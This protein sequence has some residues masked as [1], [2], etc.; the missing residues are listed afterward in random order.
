MKNLLP[1]YVAGLGLLCMVQGGI[2]LL[3]TFRSA[4]GVGPTAESTPDLS[5]ADDAKVRAYVRHRRVDCFFW[6]CVGAAT[7]WFIGFRNSW[8]LSSIGLL[9]AVSSA[10]GFLSTLR[11][12]GRAAVAAEA[13]AEAAASNAG[14]CRRPGGR[15]I[16]NVMLLCLGIAMLYF[17]SIH[18]G[19]SPAA[20][21][22]PRD[23]GNRRLAEIVTRRVERAF[24]QTG[25][26]GLVVGAI[27]DGEEMLQGFGTRQLG[28]L[29]PPDADTVF[30]IGSISKVFTGILLAQRIESGELKLDDRVADLLPEG[31]SLPEP[32]RAVTLQHC[33]THT[34][35]FPRLPENL[36]SVSN[37]VRQL[38]GGDPYRDYSEERFR[39]ALATVD[40]EF[41][42]GTKHVYSNFAVGLLG[43]VL[44]TQN[45]SDYETLIRSKICQPLG[46]PRTT[47]A[48]DAWTQEHMSAKYRSALRL[49]PASLVLEGDEW[50]IP[51]HLAGAG[52]I[53][54]TGRDMLTFLKANMG[55]I[56]TPIDAAI[57]RSHQEL[58]Q[59][60]ASSAIGMNWIRSFES[61]ISQDVIWH[62]GGTGGFR[63]YLGFTADRR[64]GVFVLSNTAISVDDMASGILK[65]LVREYAPDSSKPVTKH[66]YAK[67]APYT[68]VRW[69][70][71]RPIVQ[72]QDRWYPL[73]SIDGVPI[74]RVMSFAR[75]EFGDKARKRL[76]EDLVE[77]L[78]KMGHEPEWD[79]TL[80]LETGDGQVERRKVP[81][82][83]ENRNRVRE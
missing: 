77:L 21:S 33:T 34:S 16:A 64:F 44:S 58:F 22:P 59:E 3:L 71:D 75:R 2:G 35:G 68:G 82:T 65:A 46:M 52:A 80:G 32:A 72:I 37:A 9:W 5:A 18:V 57:R 66:G 67:V 38:F 49:G 74:D 40:L 62:N 83:E 45:G 70:N 60:S 76:A 56:S 53:R 63:A 78:S 41:A 51:N 10:R 48:N 81:M 7:L 15:R 73:V 61:S 36:L 6:F 17:S 12:S 11:Q 47:T 4:R 8:I 28:R 14:A 55:L 69:E 54:S 26:V 13:D 25:H 20:A 79:V 23:V 19:A 29:Q 30:E 24:E 27:A 39:D 31:W 43:F 50:R 1:F 42:P